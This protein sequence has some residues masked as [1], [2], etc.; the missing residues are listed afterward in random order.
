MIKMLFLLTLPLSLL[1]NVPCQ[2]LT[3]LSVVKGCELK[4]AFDGTTMSRI[5]FQNVL[6]QNQ[7]GHSNIVE[8]SSFSPSEGIPS[9]LINNSFDNTSWLH[10]LFNE[11]QVKNLTCTKCVSRRNHFRKT[12]LEG[13]SFSDSYQIDSRF[14]ESDIKGLAYSKST[15]LESRFV[16]SN[17][18]K[19]SFVDTVVDLEVT[20]STFDGSFSNSTITSLVFSR[21]EIDSLKI[22]G[23]EA[24]QLEIDAP[25]VRSIQI[26]NSHIH[27]LNWWT[28]RSPLSE[29]DFSFRGTSFHKARF[30]NSN[31]GSITISSSK[32][33]NSI[34]KKIEM[35][36][37]TLKDIIVS[38]TTWNSVNLS[39]ATLENVTFSG[40]IFA[41]NFSDTTLINCDFKNVQIDDL[42]QFTGARVYNTTVLPFDKEVALKKQIVF[43]PSGG[44]L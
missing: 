20:E 4:N 13:L 41:A 7:K 42:T 36:G 9:Q 18:K 33:K 6:V 16:D 2:N 31:L 32:F 5:Q 37:A 1:A 17:I 40:N 38:D 21:V 28:P 39:G 24:S 43:M 23:S 19:A 12:K 22:R 25:V 34:F 30:E 10:N 14:Y 3:E 26:S 35:N 8:N 44:P 15:V 27:N 11:T 29:P